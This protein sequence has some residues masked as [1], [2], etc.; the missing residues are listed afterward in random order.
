M[1]RLFIQIDTSLKDTQQSW[2]EEKTCLNL[3]LKRELQNE[4]KYK[5]YP[6]SQPNFSGWIR[7]QVVNRHSHCCSQ[8]ARGLILTRAACD[9][10]T[11]KD[12]CD[13]CFLVVPPCHIVK[14]LCVCVW[15]SERRD[16]EAAMPERPEARSLL[17]ARFGIF[18]GLAAL[19]TWH[20]WLLKIDRWIVGGNKTA[21]PKR[22]RACRWS[23]ARP[24]C[25]HVWGSEP[26]CSALFRIRRGMTA[27]SDV[28][29]GGGEGKKRREWWGCLW[30]IKML[31]YCAWRRLGPIHLYW[32]STQISAFS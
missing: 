31:S 5:Y 14:S 20:R 17:T 19:S 16:R 32:D 2:K 21:L 12:N 3:N 27:A 6:E 23:W 11:M 28:A 9:P 22:R 4:W 25:G 15:T 8:P 18:A 29:L 30:A 10:L 24:R 7:C 26:V 13:D 1:T